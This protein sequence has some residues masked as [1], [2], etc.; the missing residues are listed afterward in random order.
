[1]S[2]PADARPLQARDDGKNVPLPSADSCSQITHTSDIDLKRRCGLR[3]DFFTA[4][5]EAHLTTF[6][7]QHL[8]EAHRDASMQSD[9]DRTRVLQLAG[10]LARL[11]PEARSWLELNAEKLTRFAD[12]NGKLD[13]LLENNRLVTELQSGLTARNQKSDEARAPCKAVFNYDPN[14]KE[15]KDPPSDNEYQGCEVW[16]SNTTKRLNGEFQF[17]NTALPLQKAQYEAARD[18]L[19]AVKGDGFKDLDFTE[20]VAAQLYMKTRAAETADTLIQRLSS[21]TECELW[22]QE[23]S[24]C[25]VGVD[26]PKSEP[27]SMR[28]AIRIYPAEDYDQTYNVLTKMPVQVRRV[29]VAKKAMMVKNPVMSPRP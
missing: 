18:L 2:Q 3:R 7:A 17:L 20:R 26:F 11:S 23:F 8:R 5:R 12:S 21:P 16:L 9:G 6:F 1:M 22:P 28:P 24:P 15:P 19:S 25:R 14:A 10:F 13:R 29:P 27:L 4:L